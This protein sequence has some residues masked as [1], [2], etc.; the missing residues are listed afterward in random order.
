M[1]QKQIQQMLSRALAALPQQQK[2]IIVLKFIEEC[3]AG[4]IHKLK[5][6]AGAASERLTDEAKAKPAEQPAAGA[7]K[8][9]T[10][11]A[12]QQ[13]A[14]AAETAKEQPSGAGPNESEEIQ[15]EDTA[16]AGKE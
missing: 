16:E 1:E 3:K 9:L 10:D 12:V 15:V 7:E 11:G 6:M 8:S 5:D 13:Q 4:N 14:A 2:Q